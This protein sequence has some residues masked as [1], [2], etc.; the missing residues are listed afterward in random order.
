[1]LL[2]QSDAGTVALLSLS[3]SLSLS[4]LRV[5]LKKGPKIPRMRNGF[6]L[7]A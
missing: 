6:E 5:T 4:F 2:T 7:E 1:M 3:L